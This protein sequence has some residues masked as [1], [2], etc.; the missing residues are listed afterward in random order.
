MNRTNIK[1]DIQNEIDNEENNENVQTR[2][3]DK[4][5][6]VSFLS[7]FKVL[8]TLIQF[9]NIREQIQFM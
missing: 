8:N 4:T 2:F 7:N 3:Y 1:K 9:L 6:G 5:S